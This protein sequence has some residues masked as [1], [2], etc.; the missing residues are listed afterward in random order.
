MKMKTMMMT[1]MMS[2]MTLFSIGCSENQQTK[3]ELLTANTWKVKSF[4]CNCSSPYI[5]YV[6]FMDNYWY[7]I[8]YEFYTNGRFV[9]TRMQCA[10]PSCS[11]GTNKTIIEALWELNGQDILVKST[12]GSFA[13]WVWTILLLD[14]GYLK[15]S[16]TQDMASSS[17]IVK[18]TTI[19]EAIQ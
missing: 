17:G 13:N 11:A 8:Y 2:L 14:N 15:M 7:L 6:E 3:A 5:E 19:T 12:D 10:N 9:I 4:K 1:L 18:I 16:T